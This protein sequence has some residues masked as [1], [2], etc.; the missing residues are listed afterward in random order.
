[1]SD[2]QWR[3]VHDGLNAHNILTG[4][5][6]APIAIATGMRRKNAERAVEAVNRIDV[7]L[8]ACRVVDAFLN[9]LEDS[10]TGEGDSLRQARRRIHA[11]L[12]AA[13]DAALRP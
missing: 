12:R 1:M 13:L 10:I 6:S 4:P 3:V 8:H 7:A 2:S 11:P 5:E 9:R